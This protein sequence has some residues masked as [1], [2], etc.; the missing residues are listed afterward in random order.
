MSDRPTLDFTDLRILSAVL[1]NGATA[2]TDVDDDD[3]VHAERLAE[4]GLLSRVAPFTYRPTDATV[5][6]VSDALAGGDPLPWAP[7]FV[8]SD[9]GH[10]IAA[11]E[12]RA[13]F[14]T[15]EFHPP[16]MRIARAPGRE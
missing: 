5:K 10:S 2:P 9:C 16:G 11:S 13:G 4:R 8:R 7:G 1:T 15:C 6:A 12:W 3:V 14:R